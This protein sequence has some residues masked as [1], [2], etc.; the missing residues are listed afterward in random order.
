MITKKSKLFSLD[1][2]I[3]EKLE[4]EDNAS[5]LATL[6]FN[7]HYMTKGKFTEEEIEREVKEIE[8]EI[9]EKRAKIYKLKEIL[10]EI[11]SENAEK[12]ENFEEKLRK[13]Y[14]NTPEVEHLIHNYHEKQSKTR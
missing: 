3:C 4:K 2:D 7:K 14:G 6:L 12:Q 8:L 13:M 1:F 5:E 10:L 11:Q 9:S